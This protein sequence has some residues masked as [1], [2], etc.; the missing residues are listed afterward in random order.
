VPQW[1]ATSSIQNGIASIAL[2]GSTLTGAL[3]LGTTTN[4][5]DFTITNTANTIN[6]NLPFASA[7]NSGKLSS[8]DWNTFNNKISSSSLSGGAG[9]AYNSTTG[10]ITNTIG[11]PFPNNATTSALTFTSLTLTNLIG[12]SGTTTV[13]G[14]LI[15]SAHNTY[16]LGSANYA[17]KD[18]FVGP[19]SL[20]VNGQE[21]IHTDAS[22]NV[23]VSSDVNENLELKTSGT[24][25]VVINPSGTGQLQ[26]AGPVQ[27][28]GGKNVTTSDS[29]ALPVP[30]GVAAGNITVSGNAV[31]ATNLNGGIS[32]T[33]A[34]NGGVYVT[35]G[36]FGIGTTSPTFALSV[37]GTSYLNSTLSVGG[38]LSLLGATTTAANG[39]NIAAGCFAVNGVCVGSGSTAGYPFQLAGNAT[40]TLTQFNGGLTAYAI[41]FLIIF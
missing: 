28:S 35:N 19:G 23:I 6:F 29:S 15:P 17:W 26:I 22:Q 32:L 21:V 39:I 11:Y 4:G 7:S 10:V 5:T 36:N 3:T 27:I 41:Y 25:N 2:P 31:T 16:S 40:S 37:N 1:I 14:N 9:I 20:Y 33:P 8:A 12:A 24:A 38:V 30:F 34:G 18:V 13:T